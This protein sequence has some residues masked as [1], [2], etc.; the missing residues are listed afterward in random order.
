[1]RVID[2]SHPI[3]A[4]MPVYPGDPP[5]VVTPYQ[6]IGA[7]GFAVHTVSFG[8]HTGTHVDAP[9]HF[10]EKDMTVDNQQILDACTGEAVLID[11]PAGPGS[12]I[13]PAGLDAAIALIT[14]GARIILHTGWS[15]HFGMPEYYRDYPVISPELATLMVDRRIKLLGIDAPSVGDELHAHLLGAGIVLLE[16]LTNLDRIPV[17][18]FLLSAAPLALSGLDGSPVRACAILTDKALKSVQTPE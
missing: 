17:S 15:S 13:T 12:V 9:A 3:T 14:N 4:G 5:V 11:A 2:L 7:D 10:I 6:T 1:M 18:Q 16:N 8:T